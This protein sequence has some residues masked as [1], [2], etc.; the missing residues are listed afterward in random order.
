MCS[1]GPLTP[2]IMSPNGKLMMV[3]LH[4]KGNRNRTRDRAS[5][6]E[7]DLNDLSD[8]G[9]ES[10][11][12]RPRVKCNRGGS[13]DRPNKKEKLAPRSGQQ[14]KIGPGF[15][16]TVS[17]IRFYAR[18][19]GQEIIPKIDA[20][21][22]RG[23]D[24]IGCE[25]V[26]YK[27]NYFT[28]IASFTLNGDTSDAPYTIC[29]NEQF[30][31]V[32]ASGETRSISSLALHIASSC[33]EDDTESWLVQHTAKRDKGPQ[34]RPAVYPAVPGIL[35]PHNVIREIANIR[36]YTKIDR[37]NK[38]FFLDPQIAAEAPKDSILSTYPQGDIATAAKYERI[39]FSMPIVSRK[40]TL[41]IKHFVLHVELLGVLDT[42]EKVVL[43]SCKT[44]PLIVRGRSPSNYQVG[45]KAEKPAK[46][47]SNVTLPRIKRVHP[48][49]VVDGLKGP[50][51]NDQSIFDTRPP[52][53]G[54]SYTLQRQRGYDFSNVPRDF[55]PSDDD[56]PD[57]GFGYL[58]NSF[59]GAGEHPLNP[60]YVLFSAID[61]A[62]RNLNVGDFL[63]GT[64]KDNLAA[65]AGGS[66]A[67]VSGVEDGLIKSRCLDEYGS[68]GNLPR[69]SRHKRRAA[70]LS[71][72]GYLCSGF[73]DSFT[74]SDE[75][76]TLPLRSD[77][78]QFQ[79][80]ARSDR[81]G[82]KDSQLFL[83]GY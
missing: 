59:Q 37:F 66:S 10:V 34:T 56:Y 18:T 62:L 29:Q 69:S 78:D 25:W 8:S 67:S 9:K 14:F 58:E 42:G 20:R 70:I 57:Y 36:S 35:P 61:D 13:H 47:V 65:S 44:P 6:L 4:L 26:G 15:G 45:K 33:H 1:G 81:T 64:A 7:D 32:T 49:P 77:A 80:D 17:H 27:R 43:A 71:R 52:K 55:L 38:M 79:A 53:S 46:R 16:P 75:Y 41:A 40:S 51:V 21:V 48:V 50:V 63:L 3:T 23:F 2:F 76:T 72:S 31:C 12:K 73:D 83:F 5:T 30:H 54:N 74:R 22:D 60:P 11:R 82:S 24:R 39:Q 28:L 19:S 68:W